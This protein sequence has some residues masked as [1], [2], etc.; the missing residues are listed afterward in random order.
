[1]LETE[2]L[3]LRKLKEEDVT[4]IFNNW[5]NDPEVTKYLTWNHHTE[6]SQTKEILVLWLEEEKQ[7]T[8]YRWAIE[9]KEDHVLMG[10]MDIVGFE[11]DAPKIGY[12]LGKAYWNNG[13][14][15]EAFSRVIQDLWDSGYQRIVIEAV[16]ENIGS[17][18]VIQ[19]CGFTYLSTE[20]R[21]ASAMKPIMVNVNKY[22]LRRED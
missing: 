14:M 19:K 22:E 2:R 17:N 12:V 20:R 9:R 3:I 4:S 7:G 10:M 5:T 11:E 18:R 8:S 21:L 16:D 1:M 13:Y 6:I 15:T